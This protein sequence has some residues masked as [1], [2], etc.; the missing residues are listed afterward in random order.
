MGPEL[1]RELGFGFPQMRR[2][3]IGTFMRAPSLDAAF[4]RDRLLP[5]YEST[6]D[7]LGLDHR[8]ILLDVEDRPNKTPRAFCAPVRIPDEVHVVMPLI[9]GRDDYEALL[10]ETGHA[11]HYSYTA[12]ELPVEAR[13]LGDNS[14]TEGFATLFQ[15]LVSTPEWLTSTLGVADPQTVLAHSDAVR[16]VMLRRY[17]AK[18]LYELE[19]HGGGLDEPGAERYAARLSAALHVDWPGTTWLSDLDPFF[20]AA[21]YLRAW[22]LETHLRRL[23]V[24][25][26][27]SAWFAEIEAGALLRSLFRDG[28]ARGADELLAELSGERLDLAA[29]QAELSPAV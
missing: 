12:R 23:L 25:R 28:Q 7:G 24:E 29:V 6:L 8:R 13:Y 19:L 20:Y 4:P 27:G 17:C 26:F 9:G 14:V 3:D 15:H 11:Q 16:M 18:L 1:V 5:A 22:A 10:H 21:R 2:S